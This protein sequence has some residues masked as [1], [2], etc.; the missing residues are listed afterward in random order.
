MKRLLPI[1]LAVVLMPGILSGCGTQTALDS[2]TAELS[3]SAAE[4]AEVDFSQTDTDM[5]TNRD[6]VMDYDVKGSIL[7]QLNGSSATA[8][9]ESVLIS[10]TTV[11]ITEEA[12]YI[13]SGTL[14]DGMILVDAPDTAKLQL[15][16]NGVEISS[17]TSAPL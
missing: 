16:L 3:D 13:L 9:S 5:F 2:G 14:E 15:V 17:K 12:T 10:G 4:P 11:T 7:I 6:Y 1:I 8:R